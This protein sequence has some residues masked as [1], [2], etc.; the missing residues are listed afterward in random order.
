MAEIE[1]RGR[2]TTVLLEAGETARVEHTTQVDA[3][4]DQGFAER[5]APVQHRR[6]RARKARRRG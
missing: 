4:I 2:I 3:L 6:P 1:I 5:V